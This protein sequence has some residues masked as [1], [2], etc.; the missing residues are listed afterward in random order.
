MIKMHR[1]QQ[2]VVVLLCELVE[3]GALFAGDEAGESE[4]RAGLLAGG[5]P[6]VEPVGFEVLRGALVGLLGD[7]LTAFVHHEVL[8]GETALGLIAGAAP[9]AAHRA[10]LHLRS[11]R[12]AGH[13]AR[14]TTD[15]ATG[16]AALRSA[17]GNCPAGTAG[18]TRHT[19]NG[20]CTSS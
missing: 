10:N 15:R 7:N 3:R 9:D 6:F 17:W 12:L 20:H 18:A 19:A 1:K 16:A 2:L 8:L 13:L 4:L 14:R 11:A 5:S